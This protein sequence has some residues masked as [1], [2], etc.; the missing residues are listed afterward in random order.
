[1]S[2]FP[3]TLISPMFELT[4][5]QASDQAS[6]NHSNALCSGTAQ[7]EQAEHGRRA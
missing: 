3:A 2:Y 5:R 7:M 6:S 4:W 1:M